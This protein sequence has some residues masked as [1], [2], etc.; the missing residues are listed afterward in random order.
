MN[1]IRVYC[2]VPIAVITRNPAVLGDYRAR[3]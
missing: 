2:N 1:A 3:R